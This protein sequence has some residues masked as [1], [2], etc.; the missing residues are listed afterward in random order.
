MHDLVAT[1]CWTEVQA[2]SMQALQRKLNAERKVRKASEKWLR[3]EM[4][5]R[6]GTISC[7]LFQHRLWTYLLPLLRAFQLLHLKVPA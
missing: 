4:K 5:S 3:A 7:I 6:V 1:H 2:A